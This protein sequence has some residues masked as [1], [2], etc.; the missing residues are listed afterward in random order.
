MTQQHH[1][2]KQQILELHVSSDLKSFEL[3]NK[4]SAL[5]RSK[6]IP[7]IEAYCNRLS[8]P[9]CIHRIDSL[10]I[11]LGEIEISSLE[12]DFVQKVADNLYEQ[13]SQKLAPISAPPNN[14]SIPIERTK[15]LQPIS[16]IEANFE[17]FRYFLEMGRLPW[18]REA[19]NP[20]EF[21][22][23]F[24]KLIAESPQKTKSLLQNSLKQEKFVPRI[25]YQFSEP[26]L[27]NLL[28]L[29]APAWHPI[30]RA[31]LRDINILAPHIQSW[32]GITPHQLRQAIWRGILLQISLNPKTDTVLQGNLFYLAAQFQIDARSLFKELQI[33]IQ[34]LTRERVDFASELL[35]KIT[36]ISQDIIHEEI[37]FSTFS[38]KE[39][40]KNIEH[41]INALGN[42]KN[43]DANS[44]NLF[45]LALEIDS[46]LSQIK[47]SSPKDT[48]REPS[49]STRLNPFLERVS[50]LTTAIAKRETI[51]SVERIETIVRD[52]KS[53]YRKVARTD[54]APQSQ[55]LIEFNTPQ[56]S[57]ISPKDT[58]DIYIQNSGLVLLWP[59]LNR[60]F[61]TLGLVES[62]QFI[63][64][65]TAYQSVL[66]LQYL[67]DRSVDTLEHLLPLNKI[68]CGIDL[69]ES[70]EAHLDISEIDKDECN[71]LL[72]ATIQNW[73]ALKNTSIGGF[74]Q[75]FLQR[76]GILRSHHGDWLLQIEHQ[77]HD[78]LL[79]R[80]PWS[81]R[82]I[83]LPWMKRVLYTE[84]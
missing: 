73:S 12:T 32:R 63:A 61:E 36:T 40:S 42:L 38:E 41:L 3:Q 10:E 52:L 46:I 31:Y 50:A 39:I 66:L 81:I 75:A 65:Q 53:I 29:I 35:Q 8:N 25:L 16:P 14:S 69:T 4:I 34:N 2:I 18:W 43:L 58:E 22:Q 5:Y 13:L 60:F 80:L 74:R 9:D 19:L 83:K 6:I 54:K 1:K 44:Q 56:D 51:P 28:E 24:D 55:T 72:S 77:T 49:I 47:S 84:W 11:D 62:S 37:V 57:Y 79:D 68:L 27:M 21:E 78:I 82:V 17:L 26:M 76:S 45:S 67:A 64:P 15:S 20:R 23:L 48:D 59:F 71:A 7:L 70:V 30:V 33:I